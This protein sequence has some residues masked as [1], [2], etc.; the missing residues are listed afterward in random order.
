MFQEIAL[1]D[2]TIGPRFRQDLGDIAALAASITQTGLLH[3]I[4]VTTEHALVAGRRRLAAYEQLGRTTIEAHVID[5]D[6]PIAA[7]VDEN[8]QRK[9]YTLS[10]WVA[11]GEAREERDREKARQRQAQA[12]GKGN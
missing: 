1:T 6:D 10:E 11:I 4:I 3:P 12:G 8:G 9:D 5:L 2:I 7:E